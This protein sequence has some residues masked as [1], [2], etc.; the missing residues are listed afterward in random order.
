M[1]RRLRKR[2]HRQLL[3]DG[4]ERKGDGGADGVGVAGEELGAALPS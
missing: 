2:P 1:E 3:A 4:F